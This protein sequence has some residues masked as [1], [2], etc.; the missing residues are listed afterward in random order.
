VG[1]ALTK[2]VNVGGEV[3]IEEGFVGEIDDEGFVAGVGGA[4]EVEG[5]GVDGGSLVAHGAGIIDEDAE[6]D[7]DVGVGEGDDGLEGVVLEDVEVAL[8]EILGEVA[9]LIDDGAGEEDLIDIA[10][11]GIDAVVTLDFLRGIGVGGA[12]G[13]VVSGIGGDDGVVVDVE[14]RLKFGLLRGGYDS[15][16]GGLGCFGRGDLGRRTGDW[17]R[18]SGCGYGSGLLSVES[19]GGGGYQKAAEEEAVTAK[20]HSIRYVHAQ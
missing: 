12:D 18:R 8:L 3:L 15:G 6:G 16:R 5:G 7:G 11:K 17:L 1:E 2:L 14:R 10:A 4:H 19:Q 20:A 13:G 9:V